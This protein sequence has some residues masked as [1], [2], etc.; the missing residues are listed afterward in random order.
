MREGDSHAVYVQLDDPDGRTV[1]AGEAI[2]RSAKAHP[3][4]RAS[5]PQVG[6]PDDAMSERPQADVT[7]RLWL[8]A[9]SIPVAGVYLE[10]V[11]TC[12]WFILEHLPRRPPL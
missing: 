8:N 4:T 7:Y 6:I 9:E 5:A 10:R 2:Y 12:W 11:A 1:Y 3:R